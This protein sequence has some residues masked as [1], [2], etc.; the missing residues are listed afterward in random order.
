MRIDRIILVAGLLGAGS[1]NALPAADDDWQLF[2][3][4][5]SVMQSIVHTAAHSNDPRAVEKRIEG[6]LAGEN[7]EANRLA[8]DIVADA[9]EDMP[10]KYKGT[11][12]SL[13]RDLAALAR[14]EH[15][16]EPHRAGAGA[17][18]ALRARKDLTA[19][20]LRYFDASQFLDAVKRDDVM[21]VELFVAARGVNLDARD[22]SGLTA[23][24]LAQRRNN[25]QLID[26]LSAPRS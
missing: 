19:M 6:L 21:A 26:L 4:V 22:T 2:G 13:A 10:P 24:Q 17:E 8:A 23:L 9:F 15:L 7:A 5:L 12:L 14:K 20:G 11:V 16:R 1:A 18:P 3:R 25:R